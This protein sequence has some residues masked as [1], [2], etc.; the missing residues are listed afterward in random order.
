VS[1]ISEK[2]SRRFAGLVTEKSASSLVLRRRRVDRRV[3]V[4]APS[5][6]APARR[7]T[8]SNRSGPGPSSAAVALSDAI[9]ADGTKV[10][11][12]VDDGGD[13]DDEGADISTEA[14][15]ATRAQRR[16][17]GRSS[18]SVCESA[19]VV[20]SRSD[21]SD[22]SDKLDRSDTRRR[23]ANDMRRLVDDDDDDDENTVTGLPDASNVADAAAAVEAITN[24]FNASSDRD[25]G[26]W[27]LRFVDVDDVIE[28]V[29]EAD[30]AAID[31][32][33][34]DDEDDD[35]DG[36]VGLIGSDGAALLNKPLPSG[37][38]SA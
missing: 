5:S 25:L 16:G 23:S 2:I 34:D 17:S 37:A 24:R 20:E 1:R 26:I 13:A 32:D 4:M 38:S 3:G 35:D 31:D 6:T 10:E 28:F 11:L 14:S 27:L 12:D 9:V 19:S 8:A 29:V 30:V 7:G 22:T 18:S 33:D 15:G 36:A 21:R